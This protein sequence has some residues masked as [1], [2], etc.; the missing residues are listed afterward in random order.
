MV[1]ASRQQ[2]LQNACMP[3]ITIRDVPDAT[4]ATLAAR[5][6]SRGQ[7]MQEYLRLL[8]EEAASRPDMGE[9][10]DRIGRRVAASGIHL[11]AEEIVETL[12]EIRR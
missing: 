4:R 8:L 5:A 2:S 11:S 9:L 7:S 3:A 10:I 6:A 1:L 12:D